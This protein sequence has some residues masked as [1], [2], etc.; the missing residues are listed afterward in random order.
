MKT[1]RIL[2]PVVA[3]VLAGATVIACRPAREKENAE[4]PVSAESPSAR[5]IADEHAVVMNEETQKRI[6]LET[7]MLVG[8]NFSRRVKGYGRVLDPSPLAALAT[9]LA[10]VQI[11]AKG[12]RQ[13][14]ER[15]KI[16]KEN[17][18]AKTLQAA[19]AAFNRDTLAVESARAKLQLGWGTNFAGQGNLMEFLRPLIAA[20]KILVRIT[21]PAGENLSAAPIGATLIS[22][23]AA[24]PLEAIFFG[25]A[26]QRD[27]SM[28]GD[29]FLFLADSRSD[30]LPGTAVT[31]F[32]QF[33]GEPQQG[34]IVPR[35]AVLRHEGKTW[36]YF[37]T[38]PD[39]FSRH[40]VRLEIPT[41]GGWFVSH[42]ATNNAVVII[43]AQILLS[44]ES[45]DQ[46]GAGE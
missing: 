15:V 14:L 1:K 2:I 17:A 30:F 39:H 23:A 19:E 16:L 33:A 11:A 34:V 25:A 35:S 40:E 9:E 8:T 21:V 6:G 28:Q 46:I 45:K 41:D 5:G 7:G 12:S 13:D 44:E 20:Q 10:S 43:G 18:S 36:I 42:T 22:L 32:M 27:E 4:P 37:K 3:A 31:G 24:E 26:P 38:A 29:G